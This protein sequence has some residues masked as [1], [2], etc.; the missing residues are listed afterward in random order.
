MAPLPIK[1]SMKSSSRP[2][3]PSYLR[4]HQLIFL[5][6][7]FHHAILS[8]Q[9][10]YFSACSCLLVCSSKNVVSLTLSTYFKREVS[11][12]LLLSF[13]PFECAL[14]RLHLLIMIAL[15]NFPY[16]ALCCS[17]YVYFFESFYIVNFLRAGTVSFQYFWHSHQELIAVCLKIVHLYLGRWSSLVKYTV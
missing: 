16:Y 17:L 5:T 15:F 6:L 13:L 2:S 7:I 9:A 10:T 12:F 1:W 14:S 4:Y 11:W 8:E 3:R